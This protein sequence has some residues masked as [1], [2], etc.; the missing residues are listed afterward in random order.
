MLCIYNKTV[1]VNMRKSSDNWLILRKNDSASMTQIVEANIKQSR[2][3]QKFLQLPVGAVRGHRRF[4]PRRIVK[5]PGGE[6]FALSFP[7]QFRCGRRQDDFPC[8][9]IGLGIPRYQPA[10]PVMATEYSYL[11]FHCML[12]QE[13]RNVLFFGA[14][15]QKCSLLFAPDRLRSAPEIGIRTQ[16]F[17]RLSQ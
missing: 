13:I 3:R 16:T 9:R 7:Q 10:A 2:L 15:P 17:P 6:R 8:S 1:S 12:L 14:E 4:W 5:N 11:L